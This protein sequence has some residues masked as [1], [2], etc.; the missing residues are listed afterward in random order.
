MN[1]VDRA[2]IRNEPGFQAIRAV[3]RDRIHILPEGMVSR[4]TMRL[5]KGIVSIGRI[6]YPHLYTQELAARIDDLIAPSSVSTQ[7]ESP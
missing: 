6:L 1:Q 5:L 3:R 7:Q 2:T 4:P